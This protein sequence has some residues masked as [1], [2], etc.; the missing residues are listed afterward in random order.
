M[1][2]K[3]LIDRRKVPNF[4]STRLCHLKNLPAA[5]STSRRDN[6]KMGKNESLSDNEYERQRLLNIEKNKKLLK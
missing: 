2:R 5:S 6:K 1:A 3:S 4:P